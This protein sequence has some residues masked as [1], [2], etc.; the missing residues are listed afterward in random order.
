MEEDKQK[1]CDDAEK[2][3]LEEL[4]GKLTS[5]PLR[6]SAMPMYPIEFEKDDDT[7]FHMDYIVAASNLRAENYDIPAADRHKSKL[8]AG[9]I[10]PAIATTT[11]AVAGLMC[12][13]LYKLVQGHHKISSYRICYLILSIQHYL[14]CHPRKASTFQVAEKEYTLWDDFLV[15]GRRGGQQEMTLGD[16]L[17]YIKE[18]YGLTISY[19]L[20]GP[21]VLYRGQKDKLNLSVSDLVRTVTRADIPPHVEMLELI[22]SFEEDEDCETVPHIRYMLK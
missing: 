7:N 6:G 9:R 10:I 4:K 2:H 21:A 3:R 16:L 12:L 22:A 1:D 5:S 19:L 8:I 15:E 11:A 17:Q 20:Y 14:S 18:T 13:E